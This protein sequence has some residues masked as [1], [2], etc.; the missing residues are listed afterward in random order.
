MKQR[1]LLAMITAAPEKIN[2]S[3]DLEKIKNRILHL[4]RAILLHSCIYYRFGNSFITDEEFDRRAYE[5]KDL[6]RDYPDLSRSIL[7]LYREFQ[8]WDATTGFRLPTEDPDL[9]RK[10]AYYN[11]HWEQ[12]R[13]E[14]Y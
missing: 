10:A 5:L 1:S 7:E 11:A 13:E 8:D 12:F 14:I 3:S 2:L 4:R 9:I 6:Q